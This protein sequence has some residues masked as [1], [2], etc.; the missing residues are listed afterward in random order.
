MTRTFET[1]AAQ[2][3]I[4]LRRIEALPEG[5]HAVPAE[6]GKHILAHSETGH[7]HTVLE[8]P[9]VQHFTAMDEFRSYLVVEGDPVDL[10]HERAFDTHETLRI[11]PGIYEVRRQREYTPEG[12]RRAAD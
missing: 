4:A 11:K 12:L 5:L 8:R 9:G 2:G 3:D 6:D 1:I 7:H 10:V